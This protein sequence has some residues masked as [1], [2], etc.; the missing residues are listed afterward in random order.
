MPRTSQPRRPIPW[1][2]AVAATLALGCGGYIGSYQE[3]GADPGPWKDAGTLPDTGV[4]LRAGEVG[5][6]LPSVQRP[7]IPAAC[8]LTVH[9]CVADMSAAVDGCADRRFSTSV[10]QLVS[11]C[12]VMCADLF[13][14]VAGGCVSEVLPRAGS[15]DAGPNDDAIACARKSLIGTTWTC[16]PS[17]GW[18]QVV[19]GVCLTP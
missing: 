3:G 12:G 15:P 17:D 18:V 9:A 7:P 16:A 19:F 4:T 11:A 13:V 2:V 6:V 8:A 5:C 14:G 10:A 1:T